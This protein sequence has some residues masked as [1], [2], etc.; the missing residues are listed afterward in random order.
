MCTCTLTVSQEFGHT[1]PI[2]Y[3]FFFT[4]AQFNCRHTEEIKYM[5]NIYENVA[6]KILLDN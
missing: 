3:F 1:T 2:S 6:K 5:S 4:L